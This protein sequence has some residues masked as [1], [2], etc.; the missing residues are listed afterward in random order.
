MSRV[1]RESDSVGK[2]L[3]DGASL[4]DEAL[5][6]SGHARRWMAILLA[7]GVAWRL[8]RYGL[9][10]P[11]WG[12]EA[13]L[14]LN[15]VER[16]GYPDLLQPL[17]RLQVAPIGFL[18]AQLTVVRHL[19][20]SEYAVRLVPLLAGLAAL[21]LFARLAWLA[22]PPLAAVFAVGVFTGTHY[23]ARYALDIKPY[24]MDLMVAAMLL[25]LTVHWRRAPEERR[26]PVLLILVAPLALTLSYPGIFVA[27]AVALAQAPVLL[28]RRAGKLEWTLLAVYAAIVLAAFLA[29]MTVSGRGQYQATQDGMLQYWAR[30]LP[31]A[32][33]LSFVVWLV[34]VHTA[35]MMSYPLGGKNGAST[36][37]LILALL[38]IRRLLQR[39]ETALVLL[40]ATIF[41]LTFLAAVLRGYPYGGGSRVA[42]HLAPAI[43]LF[44]GTGLESIVSRFHAG[45]HRRRAVVAVS[46]VLLLIALGGMARDALHPYHTRSHRL[47]ANILAPL[48]H[49]PP[50]SGV[51]LMEPL[52]AMPFIVQWY[53]LHGVDGVRARL[54][55]G[56]VDPATL[57]RH[58]EWW[59]LN[60]DP[61]GEG[62]AAR[63]PRAELSAARYVL[64]ET[65]RMDLSHSRSGAL[66][67][68]I[69]LERW[70]RE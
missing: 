10:F 51:W 43:C 48:A 55:G 41:G 38:G 62:D 60:L 57:A 2:R 19:G 31:P 20:T 7:V 36:L 1:P 44:V 68:V 67:R 6:W 49:R 8:M 65:S 40:L 21:L 30:G 13:A 69:Q 46:V 15:V 11:V 56:A 17:T 24:G 27:A 28:R 9:R 37:S 61:G 34:D 22:L 26:W 58:P 5:D 42:Q 35:E 66:T 32:S 53:V 23:V 54:G 39:R 25:L 59:V 4:P 47:V 50:D 64:R 63:P 14:M 3:P 18:A 12:D 33:P 52:D 16:H 29:I 45:R 70:R